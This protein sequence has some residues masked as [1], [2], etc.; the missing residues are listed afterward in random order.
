[1]SSGLLAVL[2]SSE[3]ATVNIEPL[4]ALLCTP[5]PPPPPRLKPPNAANPLSAPRPAPS[6]EMVI[7]AP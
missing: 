5:P 1:M 4:S 2:A 7:A 6:P 3:G